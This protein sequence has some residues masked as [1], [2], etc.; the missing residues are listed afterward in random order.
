[1]F[2]I[3]G[4][5][6]NYIFSAQWDE[7]NQTP[8]LSGNQLYNSYIQHT[9][10]TNVMLMDEFN[11]LFTLQGTKVNIKTIDKANLFQF[12]NYLADF[13]A[14]DGTQAGINMVGVSLTFMVKV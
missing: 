13:R 14:I 1:M 6:L 4:V 10:G 5:D 9:W 8:K 11:S 7:T 3:N 12:R 2:S